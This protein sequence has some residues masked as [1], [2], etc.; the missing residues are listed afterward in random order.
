MNELHPN[1]D[2]WGLSDEAIPTSEPD[3]PVANDAPRET[4]RRRPSHTLAFAPEPPPAR[5]R[6]VS[7]PTSLPPVAADEFGE[8][9]TEPMIDPPR[10]SGP[11]V[12]LPS[13]PPTDSQ[14][15]AAVM[16]VPPDAATLDALPLPPPSVIRPTRPDDDAPDPMAAGIRARRWALVDAGLRLGFALAIGASVVLA[17]NHC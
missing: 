16:N 9:I 11:S 4:P 1:E 7:P 2:R 8:R 13:A 5:L 10:S 15:R 12:V 3:P 17:V 14:P 6:S